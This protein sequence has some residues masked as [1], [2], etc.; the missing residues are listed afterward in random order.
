[1]NLLLSRIAEFTHASGEFN[2]HATAIGYSIDSRTIKP[3]EL[4]FAVKGENLDGHDYVDAALKA[5][6]VGAVIAS[7][8]AHRFGVKAKLLVV[9]DPLKQLQSLAACV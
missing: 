7:D 4:F 8:Q 9:D 6:A 2:A 5:G 1:M 3:C